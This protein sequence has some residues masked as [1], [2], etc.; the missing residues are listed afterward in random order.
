MKTEKGIIIA[1]LVSIILKLMNWPF[2]GIF[3]TMSLSTL[4]IMYFPMGF[5]TLRN[6]A[7]DK[8][9]TAMSLSAGLVMCIALIGMLFKFQIW[10]GSGVMLLV[11]SVG[12]FLVL[13]RV[14]SLKNNAEEDMKA[15]YQGLFSRLSIIGLLG[16]F[17]YLIPSSAIIKVRYR[18]ED[19]E[20]LRLKIQ[21]LENPDN[22][23]FRMEHDAYMM[24]LDS[25]NRSEAS[26]EEE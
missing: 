14:F 17:L 6:A 1:S 22:E 3:L 13:A 4:A 18:N 7:S 10:P 26:S 20:V 9:N 2:G 23:A 19:P 12:T 11:G 5:L 21:M 25:I 15:Y 24:K 8:Q 16:L